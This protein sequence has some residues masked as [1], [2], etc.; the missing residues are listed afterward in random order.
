MR[1]PTLKVLAA[2]LLALM[3]YGIWPYVALW[4]LHLA[5]M[6]DDHAALAAMVDVDAVRDEIAHRLNKECDTVIG[7]LSDAFIAWLETG[8][9]QDGKDALETQVTLGWVQDQLIAATAPGLGFLSALSYGFFDSPGGFMVR[10]ER[11]DG[12]PVTLRLRLT[13]AQWRVTAVYY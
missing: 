4:N 11:G 5:V 6:H 10:M 8:I 7:E 12:T 1:T 3:V 13:G 2:L 9:R